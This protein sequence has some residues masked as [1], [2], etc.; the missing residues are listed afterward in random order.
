M[1]ADEP[2]FREA[3]AL[4]LAARRYRGHQRVI[5]LAEM[6]GGDAKLRAEVESLLASDAD[7]GE[8]LDEPALGEEF[9]LDRPPPS[10]GNR[11]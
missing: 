1:N 5:F 11:R 7:S 2:R 10:E 3:T 9:R 4:F 8:F 6:C